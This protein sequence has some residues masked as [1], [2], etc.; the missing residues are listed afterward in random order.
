MSPGTRRSEKP[1]DGVARNGTIAPAD[2][3][4]FHTVLAPSSHDITDHGLPFAQP[5]VRSP[6][7]HHQPGNKR[8]LI[9]GAD[10][11]R[12]RI[13]RWNHAML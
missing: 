4:L 9:F 5:H 1:G 8:P 11:G 7:T 6:A 10:A 12:M 13:S 2:T 3:V